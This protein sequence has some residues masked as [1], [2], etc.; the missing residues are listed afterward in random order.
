MAAG[1]PQAAL[2]IAVVVTPDESRHAVLTV[3]T[4][5]GD[6]VL[7]NMRDDIV[8]WDQTGFTWIER[9]ASSSPLEWVSLRNTSYDVALLAH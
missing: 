8:S 9:Q 7:D 3:V 2:R 1:I 4:D 6:Y 5:R